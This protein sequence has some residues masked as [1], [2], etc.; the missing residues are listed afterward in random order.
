MNLLIPCALGDKETFSLSFLKSTVSK[1]PKMTT[2]GIYTQV[3]GVNLLSESKLLSRL[4][5]N[6]IATN[7]NLLAQPSCTELIHS[8]RA[9]ME[10][11]GI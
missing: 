1:N 9:K 3:A 10:K 5:K 4:L 2:Q 11:K 6:Y 8:S 7:L